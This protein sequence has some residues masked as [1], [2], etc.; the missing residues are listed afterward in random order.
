MST[1]IG[2]ILGNITTRIMFIIYIT[3]ILLTGFFIVFGYYNQLSLQEERQYDK[4]KAIVSSVSL[5]IDGNEFEMMMKDH[6]GKDDIKTIDQ[7]HV[8][9]TINDKLSKAVTENELN[10]PM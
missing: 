10:S 6:P 7:N 2:R 9:H 3:I 5:A 8:Y 4:L 1:L